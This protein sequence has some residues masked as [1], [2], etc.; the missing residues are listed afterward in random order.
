MSAT[1]DSTRRRCSIWPVA[2]DLGLHDLHAHLLANSPPLV[3]R[4]RPWI[5]AVGDNGT[6]NAQVVGSHRMGNGVPLRRHDQPGV[7]ERLLDGIDAEVNECANSWAI[8]S[9]PRLADHSGRQH[10]FTAGLRQARA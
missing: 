9:C 6:A 5:H 8:A 4:E 1:R 10:A 7:P 2:H 3:A